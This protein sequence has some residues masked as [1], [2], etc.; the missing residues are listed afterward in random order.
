MRNNQ[1]PD[2]HC[3]SKKTEGKEIKNSRLGITER[4]LEKYKPIR[5]LKVVNGSIISKEQRKVA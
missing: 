5:C 3:S 2:D 4:L 1:A